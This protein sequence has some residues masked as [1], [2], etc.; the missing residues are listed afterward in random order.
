MTDREQERFSI[1]CK[2]DRD[3][4]GKE[5]NILGQYSTPYSLASDIMKYVRGLM[6]TP[7]VSFLEPAIGTGVFYSAFLDH[8]NADSRAVG[9]EIDSCYAE[10]SRRLWSGLNLDLRQADFL[11]AIPDDKYSLIVTNPP[12]SRHHHIGAVRKQYLQAQVEAYAGVRLSG[13]SGLY[14]YF[15]IL[16]TRWL[17]QGGLSCWLV[18]SEFMDVNYGKGIKEYLA[19]N[20]ELLSIHRFEP[21]D[22]Q[23][24]D[25]LVTSSVVV[26]R[27]SPPTDNPV[28][29]SSG[30]SILHPES[31]MMVTRE[32]LQPSAKWSQL[33]HGFT[34]DY[35]QKTTRGDYF[36]VKRG[37]ATGN[38]K[39]FI[40]TAATATEYEIP[41]Q[42]LVPVLPA[43]RNLPKDEVLEETETSQS[44]DRLFLLR[45]DLHEDDLKL[46]YPK[47]WT[48]IEKGMKEGV[49]ERYNCRSRDPWY[50]CE[51]REPSPILVTYMGRSDSNRQVFRF[52]M[53]RTQA[54]ATNSY[55][56]L[57]PKE[58][59]KYKMREPEILRNVWKALNSI[60]KEELKKCGRVY[61]GGLYKLEPKELLQAPARQLEVVL[62]REPTL[63]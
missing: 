55:L 48:Y 2:L 27:N 50:S 34:T 31:S 6:D 54:V 16:S 62:G 10:P 52:I 29:F 38:N 47:L 23:F 3:K 58:P 32:K 22:L 5:R 51:V 24:A 59:F 21:S 4:Q 25:A 42:F 15:L 44:S 11:T 33:F 39:F 63:F 60:P 56:L 1:Q 12:Y 35:K 61:G 13:L 40:V 53:N 30:G 9:Y 45:C 36:T 14:A 8:F 49:N 20:V 41:K 37:I 18:P 28:L 17:C 46:S 19:K 7:V 26:F 43:P 57:Y